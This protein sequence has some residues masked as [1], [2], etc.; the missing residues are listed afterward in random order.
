MK[1]KFT[2]RIFPSLITEKQT[3]LDSKISPTFWRFRVYLRGDPLGVAT[4]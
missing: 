3:K 4:P 2:D 1:T